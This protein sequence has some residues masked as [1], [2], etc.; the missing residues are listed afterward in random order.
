MPR[1]P[2]LDFPD[3]VYHVT[4]RGNGR[5]DIFWSDDDRQ[6]F[7][8]QLAHH[9]H[10]TAVVLYAYVLLDNH[11][12]LLVRTPRGNLSAFMQRLLTGGCSPRIACAVAALG[13]RHARPLGKT[14]HS[15]GGS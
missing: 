13:R 1:P 10:V 11:F 3:V 4:S 7:L 12:H 14:R 5:A 2:R 9:L 8:A 15:A 6:R